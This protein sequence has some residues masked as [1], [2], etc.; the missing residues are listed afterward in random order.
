MCQSF[1]LDESSGMCKLFD[2]GVDIRSGK[3]TGTLSVYTK[4]GKPT[5]N[6]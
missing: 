6:V 5:F 4:R 2:K 3:A 1:F